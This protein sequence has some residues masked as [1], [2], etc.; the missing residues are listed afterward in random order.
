LLLG[1][2]L[3][4]VADE[5]ELLLLQSLM[6]RRAEKHGFSPATGTLFA[7]ATGPLTD[8]AAVR[9]LSRQPTVCFQATPDGQELVETLRQGVNLF[10]IPPPREHRTLTEFF[11]AVP[12]AARAYD[13]LQAS[14]HH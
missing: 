6:A 13:L 8:T 2:G 5:L 1:T 9:E 12:D 3:F 4:V 7:C 14:V 11:K 10:G